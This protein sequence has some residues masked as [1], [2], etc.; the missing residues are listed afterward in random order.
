MVG[1]VY[2]VQKGKPILGMQGM[3]GT[4]GIQVQA[5]QNRVFSAKRS[6]HTGNT[7]NAGNTGNGGTG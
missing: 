2:L 5:G 6:T 4:R 3:L 1:I 7:W